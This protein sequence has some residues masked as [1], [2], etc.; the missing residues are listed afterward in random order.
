MYGVVSLPHVV[1]IGPDG[2]IVAQNLSGGRIRQAVSQ[3]LGGTE[4]R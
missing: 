4:G 1:L 3:V 2:K